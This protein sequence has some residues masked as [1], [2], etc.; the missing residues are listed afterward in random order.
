MDELEE[1]DVSGNAL[2]S[3]FTLEKLQNHKNLKKLRVEST[4]C[5]LAGVQ[6]LQKLLSACTILFMGMEFGPQ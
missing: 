4:S 6:E 5:N 1:L 3:N 2:V